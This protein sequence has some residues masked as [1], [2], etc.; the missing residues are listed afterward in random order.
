M[1]NSRHW[2]GTWS[3]TPAPSEAGVGFMNHTLRMNP[4]VSVGGETLRIRISNA[5][6]SGKLVIGAATIIVVNITTSTWICWTSLVM[7]VIS[8]GAPNRPTSRAE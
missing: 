8:D 2:V 7:R 3:A 6:G 5:Y 4:R 1:E